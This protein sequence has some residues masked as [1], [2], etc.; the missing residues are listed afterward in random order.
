LTL[1]AHHIPG[2][3]GK[4]FMALDLL[5]LERKVI[6]FDTVS[7]NSNLALAQFLA[8]TLGKA[9]IPANVLANRAGTHANVFATLG[10]TDV[11]GLML[12]GHMDVVPVDGQKW[13]SDP[14]SLTER[15]GKFFGRGTADMKS[16]IV[17]AIVAA[18][19]V[20]HKK[21]KVPLHLAF[22]YD[23]EV[24]C[25]GAGH[26]IRALKDRKQ[27]LPA[28][29][30]V[31]EPTNFQVFTRHKGFAACKATV[32]GIEGHSSKPGKGANAIQQAALIIGKLREIEVERMDHRSFESVFEVPYTTLNVGMISGGTAANI[33]P[34][35]CEVTFEYRTMPGE[36]PDYVIKQIQGYVKEV[37]L[38]EFRKQNPAVDIV[39]EKDHS[40]LPME[41]PNGS[42][43]EALA[44]ELTRNTKTGAAPYYTEGAI[45]NESGIPTVVCGPGD[46]DQAHRPN[47]YITRDQLD[48]GVPFL[49]RLIERV[50]G[51]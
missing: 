14:F 45:Y 22:T 9:G 28:M 31:G 46:I 43:I 27:V 3:K 6:G 42:A 50:C 37:L 32:T 4:A 25:K 41:T 20:K 17:Q 49:G 10:P 7:R 33:I 34:N 47:E 44:L 18:E 15:N 11:G 13:D 21:L 30:I 19:L 40:G 8:D 16:F 36:D 39:V 12:A 5:D 48:Q 29:A 26:L 2:L 1:R 35:H 23:E 38:P 51:A 24:G